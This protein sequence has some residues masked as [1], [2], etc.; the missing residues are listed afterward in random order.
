MLGAKKVCGER[1]KVAQETAIK[2]SDK[3]DQN[4][5]EISADA[6]DKG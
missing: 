1:R 4:I 6:A 2:E 5:D 3:P